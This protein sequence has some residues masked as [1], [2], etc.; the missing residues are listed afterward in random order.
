[1]KIALSILAVFFVL[2]AMNVDAQLLGGGGLL[3]GGGGQGEQATR[4]QTIKR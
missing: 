2:A 4:A 1:M 3:N